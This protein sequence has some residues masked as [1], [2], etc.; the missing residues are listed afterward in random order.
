M[1]FLGIAMTTA[2]K[3]EQQKKEIVAAVVELGTATMAKKWKQQKKE[4]AV[5]NSFPC[6]SS[7]GK[8]ESKLVRQSSK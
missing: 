5:A 6:N 8:P 1:T 7:K 2:T 4:F 3:D